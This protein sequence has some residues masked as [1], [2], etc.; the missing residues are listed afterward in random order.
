LGAGVVIIKEIFE[1]AII[2]ISYLS[3]SFDKTVEIFLLLLFVL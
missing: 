3:Q 1:E 2:D